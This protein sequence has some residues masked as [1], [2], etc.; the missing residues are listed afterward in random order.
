[1]YVICDLAMH[2]ILTKSNN[3][4]V[5]DFTLDAR[6]P[7]MYYQAQPESYQNVQNYI[8]EVYLPYNSS[9]TTT[10]KK[11]GIVVPVSLPR[12]FPPR[13]QFLCE[14]YFSNVR[15][16]YCFCWQTT[17]KVLRSDDEA[18]TTS[19][20]SSTSPPSPALTIQDANQSANVNS[21]NS[22]ANDTED[23]QTTN[24]KEPTVK[25]RSKQTNQTDEN[26]EP[27]AKRLR[28]RAS[29]AASNHQ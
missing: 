29:T 19:A 24:G 26:T 11:T 3:Y 5:R 12:I 9:T 16:L 17:R 20:V 8:P 25:T 18:A 27:P 7:S 6:I 22:S 28:T 1:M 13:I 21:T 2:I 10:T 15:F 14:K 23:E 4:D